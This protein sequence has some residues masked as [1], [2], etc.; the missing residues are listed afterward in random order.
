MGLLYADFCTECGMRRTAHPS[1]MCCYC[2]K[3]AARI[4][5]R[6][7]TCKFCGNV[8]EN[9]ESGLCAQ[10]QRGIEPFM[11]DERKVQENALRELD[12]NRQI[13]VL[14]REGLPFDRIADE[15]GLAK[16]AVYRRYRLL[17]PNVKQR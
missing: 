8:R 2:R 11:T 7:M 17:V 14:H 13:I 1:G 3:K 16:T 9:M 12:I 10:C 15:V 5:S 6:K 4:V